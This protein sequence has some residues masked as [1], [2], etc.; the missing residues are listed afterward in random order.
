MKVGISTACLYPQETERALDSLLRLGFR[1][2][3]I[4]V[5]TVSEIESE[6]IDSMRDMVRSMG[7]NIHSLHPFTSGYESMLLFSTYL[8][9]YEDSLEFYRRYFDAAARAGAKL[10]V[11]HGE[12]TSP[13]LPSLPLEEYCRRFQRLNEIAREYGVIM[14]QEN[15][16]GFRS[17]DPEFLKGMRHCL[18]DE[19]KFVLDIKQS[20]RAGFTPDLILDAMG[21]NVIH[22]HVNDHTKDRDCML[23]G[24]GNTD[25]RALKKRLD[26]M[27]Y[28][29]QWI[30][31]VYRKDF[32]EEKELLDSAH[33]LEGVLNSH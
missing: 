6:F 21:Q 5:N 7:G 4:F 3:E 32:N 30:I 23:P 10:V 14:A 9:R 24:R 8:R 29:G 17:Q 33:Y 2:F 26:A 20:V 11:L 28:S 22:V 12:K 1:N 15:V 25:Y 16:N 31:E 19:V 27:G 13:K 18:G